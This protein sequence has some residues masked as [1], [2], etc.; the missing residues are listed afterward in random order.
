MRHVRGPTARD[1]AP[2]GMGRIVTARTRK[3]LSTAHIGKHHTQAT[4][5]KI[6]RSIRNH[7]TLRRARE[8]RLIA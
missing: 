7:W 4:R 3:R 1:R 6:A 2:I 5:D 8:N